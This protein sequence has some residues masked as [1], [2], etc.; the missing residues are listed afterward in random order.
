ME[1]KSLAFKKLNYNFVL[2]NL[3]S[4]NHKMKKV[5]LQKMLFAIIVIFSFSYCGNDDNDLQQNLNQNECD[6]LSNLGEF[7]LLDSSKFFIPYPDSISKII[8]SDESGQEYEGIVTSYTNNS[9]PSFLSQPS[10]C[11]VDSTLEITYNWIAESINYYVEIEEL[12]I[13]IRLIVRNLLASPKEQKLYSDFFNFILYSPI[14]STMPSAQ[15]TI[16][17]NQRTHPMPIESYDEIIENFEMDGN[18]YQNIYRKE[19]SLSNDFELLYNTEIGI[20]GFKKIGNPSIRIKF[21]RIE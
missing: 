1:L 18:N 9:L 21:E 19:Q 5:S 11:P 10:P 15:M 17:V 3:K 2:Y 16:V 7:F 8:F 12:D 20:V 6:E 14:N 4:S 13:Q